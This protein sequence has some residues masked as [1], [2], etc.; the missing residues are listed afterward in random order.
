VRFTIRLL[1]VSALIASVAGCI[2]AQSNSGANVSNLVP[3]AAFVSSQRYTNAFF[4]FSLTLPQGISFKQFQL[5]L[6]DP[7]RHFLFGLHAGLAKSDALNDRPALTTIGI[8]S[9]QL[10]HEE[11]VQEYAKQKKLDVTHIKIRGREFWKSETEKNG[12]GGKLRMIVYLTLM[13]G[14]A[15]EFNIVSFDPKLA[16]QLKQDI[17]SLE[18]FDPRRVM[19]FAGDNSHLYDPSGSHIASLSEGA[20]SSNTYTNSELDFTYQF[21]AGWAL[22]DGPTQE[23]IIEAGHKAA[24]GDDTVAAQEHEIVQKCTRILLWV[25]RY[26]P[27][28]K[29]EGFNPLITLLA[30]DPAC[31]PTGIQFPTSMDDHDGIKQAAG[32]IFSSFSDAPFFGKGQRVV[33]ASKAGNHLWVQLSGTVS[34]DKPGSNVPETAYTSI[35]VTTVRDYWLAWLFVGGSQVELDQIRSTIVNFGSNPSPS[36]NSR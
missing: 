30:I 34:L 11:T 10:Q 25:N 32:E 27:G 15:I 35:E 31:S 17:E 6:H 7:S 28:V 18:F 19:E 24:W 9:E 4:G 23:K 22:I 12:P 33:S 29:F 20:I 5:A 13:Q 16:G 1:L 21:P 2:Y 3:E 36:E 14:Y 26:A 8:S